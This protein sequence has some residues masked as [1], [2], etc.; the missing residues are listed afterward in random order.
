[1][2]RG[3]NA[4]CDL[5][6]Q[7][8][9]WDVQVDEGQFARVLHNVVL[10]AVQSMPEGGRVRV[11]GE[12]VVLPG[13]VP[14]PLPDGSY[15]RISVAD[16]GC[17]IPARHLVRIFDPFFT[18]KQTGS[19]LG[20]AA[21][22]SII[23]NH[24]GHIIVESEPG[25]GSTFRIFL[26]ASPEGAPYRKPVSAASR[27]ALHKKILVM[28]DEPAVRKMLLAMLQHLGCT[29]EVVADGAEAV[30]A[31][32]REKAAGTP[33]DLVI[34]DLTVPGAMGGRDALRAL[35]TIDPN[36]R[37]VVASGYSA[38]TTMARF[39]Q[40]GF[41]GCLTKPFTLEEL[42]HSLDAA[43]REAPTGMAP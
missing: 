8:G 27:A 3:S 29:V 11:V 34:L 32:E 24:G 35:R 30:R 16:E 22:H 43:L 33:F 7:E 25:Q 15:V 14:V 17:G 20:L 13:A 18:T 28:D 10:N 19:G 31:Y 21:S 40:E 2:L 42:R 38:D 26:P 37:A 23:K 39:R 41:V 1:V 12:N 5:T 9:L 4:A 36:V 6:V